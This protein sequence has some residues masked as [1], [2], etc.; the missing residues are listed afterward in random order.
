MLQSL[1]LMQTYA[2]ATAEALNAQLPKL[3]AATVATVASGFGKPQRHV[4]VRCPAVFSTL[5]LLEGVMLLPSTPIRSHARRARAE[6]G[7]EV[8]NLMP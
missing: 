8:C 7:H 1:A 5:V 2:A 4:E 6:A 3:A